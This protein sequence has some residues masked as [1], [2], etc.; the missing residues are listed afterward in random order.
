VDPGTINLDP[1]QV[2]RKITRRTRAIVP[3]HW[4]GHPAEMDALLDIA[5][6]RNLRI[7]EDCAHA[8]GGR[9]KGRALGTIGDLSC[10][11]LQQSKVITS[12]G[13]GG[14]VAT[15]DDDLASKVSSVRSHGKLFEAPQ[16]GSPKASRPYQVVTIGNNYRMGE[17]HAAFALVQLRKLDQ[18]H[19]IRRECAEYL[20][21][22]LKDIPGLILQDIR[23]DVHSAYA[24]FP[25]R[26]SQAHFLQGSERIS[27][28]LAAEGVE[29][30]PMKEELSHVHPLF[31]E[32]VGYPN[33]GCPYRCPHYDGDVEY[34]YG[35][36]P[37]AERIADELLILPLHPALTR[38]ELDDIAHAVRK[39]AT[40]YFS[41]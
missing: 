31:T 27:Q 20:R 11:S 37:V 18:F 26:F 6:Q 33:V 32:K 15:D 36:L 25:V 1:E 34:G 3:V 39:V 12:A 29:N 28:A 22:Q 5:Q 38:P 7:I 19:R 41:A 14:M 9:Y 17:L 30:G 2:R 35:T 10:W 24:Y 16:T 8:F 23:P 4:F 40:A 21:E 13:E